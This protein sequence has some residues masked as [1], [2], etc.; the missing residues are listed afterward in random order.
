MRVVNGAMS[1]LTVVHA[2]VLRETR[3]RFGAHRLGYLWALLEPVLMILTFYALFALAGRP[4]S[5]GMGLIPFL[6]TGIVTYQL[7][8]QTADRV[9]SSVSANKALLFYPHVHPL[10]LVF[11]RS[12]LEVATF[13]TVFLVIVGAHGLVVQE[14]T[15]DSALTTVVGALLAGALG[16]TLGLVFC[17]LGVISNSVDRVRGP[18]IRPLFWISGLFYSAN[19]LPTQ[20]REIMLWNPVLHCTELVRDGWFTSYTARY[21]SPTYVMGWIVALALLGLVLER[22]VREKV[23]LT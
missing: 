15:V 4:S 8:Q 9:A 17:S 20:I 23:Q 3:T 1:Q 19:D 18:L 16:A 11:A 6:A 7:F 14:L 10:D 12:A 5:S 22:S 2:L 13:V 21:A